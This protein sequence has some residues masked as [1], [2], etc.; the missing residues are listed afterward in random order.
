MSE[1]F[2][3][4]T[5]QYP[6]LAKIAPSGEFSGG[7]SILIEAAN[8]LTD[9]E[10]IANFSRELTEWLSIFRAK[11]DEST[12]VGGWISYVIGHFDNQVVER[13]QNALPQSDMS[14][15]FMPE[16]QTLRLPHYD[17]A[18]LNTLSSGLSQAVRY[19][20]DRK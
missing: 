12:I 18:D 6:V 7:V 17:P 1:T 19:L 10:E 15:G 14:T 13:W 8:I 3:F 11:G 5:I 16:D 9:P 4:S 2:K 20:R